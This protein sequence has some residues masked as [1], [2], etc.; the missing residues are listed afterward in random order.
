[1]AKESRKFDRE[2]CAELAKD[3]SASKRLQE[4]RSQMAEKLGKGADAGNIDANLHSA[5][6][7]LAL[8]DCAEESTSK[9]TTTHNDDPYGRPTE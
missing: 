6:T 7:G 9:S 4:F 5:F 2:N 1:M 8:E 3:K